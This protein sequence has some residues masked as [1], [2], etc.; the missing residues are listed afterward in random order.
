[1][2]SMAMEKEERRSQGWSTLEMEADVVLGPI[3][4]DWLAMETSFQ[5]MRSLEIPLSYADCWQV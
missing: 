3:L 1:M 5:K 4:C 2:P